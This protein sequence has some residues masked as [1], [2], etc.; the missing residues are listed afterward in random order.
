MNKTVIVVCPEKH[1]GGMTASGLGWTDSGNKA[2]VGGISREFLQRVRVPV[3][4]GRCIMR[5]T[6]KKNTSQVSKV[7]VG[8]VVCIA[9]NEVKPPASKKKNCFFA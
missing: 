2:A 7:E 3:V 1:I 9:T 8:D 4:S 5:T 6:A